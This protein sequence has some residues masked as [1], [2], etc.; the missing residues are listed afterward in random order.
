MLNTIEHFILYKNDHYFSSFPSITLLKDN[1]LLLLF[2]RARDSRWLLDA[3]DDET[4]HIKQ[5]VDHVD[6]RS[7]ITRIYFDL[8]LNPLTEPEALSINPEA[9]DQDASILTLANNKLLL[10]SFSWYP[11]HYEIANA[12]RK[13]GNHL[14]GQ[15]QI[16]GCG[17]IL[18][19]VFTRLSSD[20]GLSWSVHNYLPELPNSNDII[21]GHR[22]RLGGSVRGQAIEVG[23]E[24]LLPVYGNQKKD[25]V[26]TSH[27]YVSQDQGQSWQYRSVIA[28]DKKQRLDLNEPSLLHLGDKKIM[29]FMRNSSGN[30]QLVTAISDDCGHCWQDW[31][32]RPITGHPTHPLRLSDGRIFICYGYRHEPYGV[33]GH[34][35]DSQANELIGEEIIIRDDGL[36]GDVGY[37]WSVEMPDG[38]ILVVYY[39]TGEDGIRHIAGSLLALI[40]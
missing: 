31:Q 38:R 12:L 5:Q 34:L 30:D 21:P 3:I 8:D 2:R 20:S 27:L 36:C 24:I 7:Q 33:R 16:T 17:Y 19:G 29:A 6:S 13:Q 25:K 4:H 14:F 32:E 28:R 18:W 23:N 40:R 22:A 1:R 11:I 15:P 37:P 10:S 9:A 39:F 35:M 26:S